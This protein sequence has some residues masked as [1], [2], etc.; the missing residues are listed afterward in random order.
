MGKSELREL[1]SRLSVLIEH[2]L[3]IK[4][5]KGQ[6]GTDNSRGWNKSLRNQRSELVIHLTRHPG[7][8]TELNDALLDKAHRAV[9][10]RLALAYPGFR[11]PR[12]RQLSIADVVGRDVMMILQR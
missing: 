1:E 7:L 3:K 12:V 10:A 8:K 2:A 9:L 5:V 11:F 6:A 4:Y